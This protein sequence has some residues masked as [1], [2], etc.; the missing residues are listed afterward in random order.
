MGSV[1]WVPLIRGLLDLGAGVSGLIPLPLRTMLL[2]SGRWMS[3]A[4]L[5]AAWLFA[6]GVRG[7]AGAGGG[8]S[9]W[10]P[11]CPCFSY[12]PGGWCWN[13]KDT[14]PLARLGFWSGSSP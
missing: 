6:A 10:C 7:G 1:W 8:L 5:G 12:R 13:W 4:L 2:L 11:G 9:S 3:L 14:H